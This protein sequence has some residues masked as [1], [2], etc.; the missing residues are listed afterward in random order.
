MKPAVLTVSL[1]QIDRESHVLHVKLS[2][3][4]IKAEADAQCEAINNVAWKGLT[5]L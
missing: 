3:E 4:C 2:L 5:E 1:A